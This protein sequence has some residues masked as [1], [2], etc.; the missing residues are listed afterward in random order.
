MSHDYF[1]GVIYKV[2]FEIISH[3]ILTDTFCLLQTWNHH[4]LLTVPE[5]GQ[6]MIECESLKCQHCGKIFSLACNLRMHIKTVHM[7]QFLY[8]CE[9]CG[10]GVRRRDQLQSHMLAK[11]RVEIIVWRQ[12]CCKLDMD[13]SYNHSRWALCCH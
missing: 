12:T 2:L 7:G 9:I 4:A 1:Y 6:A 10:K 8:S 11:H 5:V 13:L 3:F